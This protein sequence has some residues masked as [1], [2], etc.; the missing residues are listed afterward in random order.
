MRYNDKLNCGSGFGMEQ[1]YRLKRNFREKNCQRIGNE[2]EVEG[3]GSR[4]IG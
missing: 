3:K 2:F 1:K 4:K